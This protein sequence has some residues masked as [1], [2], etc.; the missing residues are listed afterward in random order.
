VLPG[1]D[2][3][4]NPL[5]RID[6]PI[7]FRSADD[8]SGLDPIPELMVTLETDACVMAALQSKSVADMQ[9]RFDDGHRAYVARLDGVLTAWGWVAT[10]KASVGEL[11]FEFAIPRGACYLWNFVTLPSFRGRGIYPR[12]LDAIVAE[13]SAEADEF[14]IAYAPENRASAS[15]IAKAGF[16]DVAELSFDMDGHAAVR[17][18]LSGGGAAVSRLLGL[19]EAVQVT[20]CWKCVRA[21]RGA[22]SCA[23]GACCCDYQRPN[24]E[25][26]A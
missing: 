17:S 15:G 16:I 22:M 6:V 21:G 2:W 3:T 1:L 9:R 7:A 13:E 19:A 20:P 24:E 23:E 8:S 18:L 4:H 11:K 12:L 5:E 25:C 14:W 26:A 10:S